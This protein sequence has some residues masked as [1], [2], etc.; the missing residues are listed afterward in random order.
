MRVLRERTAARAG[1]TAGER[2][3]ASPARRG[4]GLLPGLELKLAKGL[5][6]HLPGLI[7]G[8]HAAR[9]LRLVPRVLHAVGVVLLGQLL[10]PLVQ[11]PRAARRAQPAH[12]VH[13]EVGQ[14]DV[15]LHPPFSN[16]TTPPRRAPRGGFFRRK[17]AEKYQ[18]LRNKSVMAQIYDYLLCLVV[19]L[20]DRH[21]LMGRPHRCTRVRC[22]TVLMYSIGYI[23]ILLSTVKYIIKYGVRVRTG[24]LKCCFSQL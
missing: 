18:V 4:A 19:R 1:G 11:V 20:L 10:P 16:E 5:A 6:E 15:H 8:G 21:S 22:V 24:H 3:R 14:R 23:Y 7:D 12:R 17:S 9:G 2:G 13:P